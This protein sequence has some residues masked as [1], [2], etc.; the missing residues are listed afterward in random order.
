[1]ARV[2][3]KALRPR[4]YVFNRLPASRLPAFAGRVKKLK[5]EETKEAQAVSAA[6]SASKR[7]QAARHA[8]NIMAGITTTNPE[9]EQ[10]G[11]LE[12]ELEEL[13]ERKRTLYGQLRAK[14]AAKKEGSGGDAMRT[15][16]GVS[17]R[18]VERSDA[19]NRRMVSRDGSVLSDGKEL[20]DDNGANGKG[21]N[22]GK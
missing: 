2:S 5:D 6:L 17:A 21:G 19:I 11:A 7:R 16:G 9:T 12:R 18:D 8:E 3:E 1:M 22:G 14:I 13:R 4:Q 20:G 15:T 10:I